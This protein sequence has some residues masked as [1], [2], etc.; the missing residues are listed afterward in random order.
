MKQKAKTSKSDSSK[1]DAIVKRLFQSLMKTNR[2]SKRRR[3]QFVRLSRNLSNTF[4][5]VCPGVNNELKGTMI[6]LLLDTSDYS[7]G[8]KKDVQKL[9]RLKHP[10]DAQTLRSYLT[11]MQ[12]L[13][14]QHQQGCIAQLRREIPIL[15][16]S[17]KKNEKGKQS[18]RRGTIDKL[19]DEFMAMVPDE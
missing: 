5:H 8:I 16:R 17:I 18:K 14:L 9:T 11:D 3:K 4:D 12:L 2:M 1:D 7:D 6:A 15:V 13:R 10:T 19:T